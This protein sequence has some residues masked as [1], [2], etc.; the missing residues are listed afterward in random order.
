MKSKHSRMRIAEFNAAIAE[1]RSLCLPMFPDFTFEEY[2][3]VLNFMRNVRPNLFTTRPASERFV[4][5]V[6]GSQED[7]GP[8]QEN[9]IR[10]LEDAL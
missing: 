1:M 5:L 7:V 10:C 3:A 8:W 6:T 4:P 2:M 9:A